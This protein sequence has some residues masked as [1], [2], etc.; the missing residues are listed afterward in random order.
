MENNQRYFNPEVKSTQAIE[1]AVRS[2]ANNFELIY[3]QIDKNDCSDKLND[4]AKHEGYDSVQ[5]YLQLIYE[6][7]IQKPRV[8]LHVLRGKI[9]HW[10]ET[11][12]WSTK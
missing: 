9:I 1:I 3:L 11:K 5:E 8:N 4:I 6:S 2:N 7:A 10:S 12:Y